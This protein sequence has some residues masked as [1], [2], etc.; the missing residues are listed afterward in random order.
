MG[1][2]FVKN[3]LFIE[4]QS[5]QYFQGKGFTELRFVF[6]E[7]LF[8]EQNQNTRLRFSFLGNRVEYQILVGNYT[9]YRYHGSNHFFVIT[10]NLD[11]MYEEIK[12][13]IKNNLIIRQFYDVSFRHVPNPQQ[14]NVICIFDIRFDSKI[15]VNN[16]IFLPKLC[17]I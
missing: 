16:D 11:W 15:A 4:F 13:K 3:N 10:P 1:L 12:I 6:T 8:T 5:F 7:Q 9:A 14:P 17:I 2:D